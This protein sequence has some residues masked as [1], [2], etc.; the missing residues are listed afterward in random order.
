M[1]DST[2]EQ[3]IVL[4]A[5]LPFSQEPL[6]LPQDFP[7]AMLEEMVRRGYERIDGEHAKRKGTSKEFSHGT[8]EAVGR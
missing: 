7:A 1:S 8:S 3:P 6:T 2:I 4:R 5:P